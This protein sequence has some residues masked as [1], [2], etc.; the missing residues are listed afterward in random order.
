MAVK[1]PTATELTQ[2]TPTEKLVAE[3]LITGVSNAQGADDLSMSTGTFSAHVSSIGRKFQVTSRKGRAARAHAVLASGQVA[4]PVAPAVVPDFTHVE[5]RLLRA[6]AE[7]PETHDISR[8]AGI[9][10]ADV[11][12]QLRD[13][14][15][16]AVADNDTHLIGLGHAWRLLGAGGSGSSSADVAA[17]EP[18][19]AAS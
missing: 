8:A 10:L 6:L 3:A 18:G 4:P 15:A 19:G 1:I 9:P 13:L 5:L 12:P 16:K 11:R 14:V 17:T 2:L 7:H